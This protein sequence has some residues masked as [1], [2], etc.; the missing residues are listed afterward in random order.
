MLG[1]FLFYVIQ[2]IIYSWYNS[3]RS[4]GVIDEAAPITWISGEVENC[5][6]NELDGHT[7]ETDSEMSGVSDS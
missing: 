4:A 3:R 5:I 7:G 1:K 6:R 2:S